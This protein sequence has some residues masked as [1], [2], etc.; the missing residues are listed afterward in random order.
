[1]ERFTFILFFGFFQMYFTCFATQRLVVVSLFMRFYEYFPSEIDSDVYN[2]L[3]RRSDTMRSILI[4]SNLIRCY[5][6]VNKPTLTM[7]NLFIDVASQN[8]QHIHSFFAVK[9]INIYGNIQL[10]I[11]QFGQ[12]LNSNAS[13]SCS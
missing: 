11:S 4:V 9:F 8:I 1:M 13:A 10:F 5:A 7:N 6:R 3:H 2:M 12:L